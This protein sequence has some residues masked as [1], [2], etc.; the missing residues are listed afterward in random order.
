MDISWIDFSDKDRKRI[1][2]IIALIHE[3]GAVDELGIGVIRDHFAEKF[4]PGTSTIQTK[5]KYFLL[6]TYIFK[7]LEEEKIKDFETYMKRL[8]QKEEKCAKKLLEIANKNGTDKEGIIGRRNI[9]G[10]RKKWVRRRPTEIYWGGLRTY[11]IFTEKEF[12]LSQYAKFMTTDA[13]QKNFWICPPTYKQNWMDKLEKNGGIELNKEE[14]EF[15]KERII[16]KQGNTL[17]GIILKKYCKEFSVLKGDKENTIFDNLFDIV[18][19]KDVPDEIKREYI[20]AKNISDFLYCAQIRYN[21][22]L[23][24][25]KLNP[26]VNL[27]YV[28]DLKNKWQ[29]YCSKNLKKIAEN[30]NIENIK[31]VI[32]D[33]KLNEFLDKLKNAMLENK[34]LEEK[35]KNIDEI[36]IE[37]EKQKKNRERAK[38][39]KESTELIDRWHGIDKLIYRTDR[40]HELILDIMKGLEKDVRY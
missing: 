36:V 6:N 39:N 24:N 14:A 38:L 8:D 34:S 7:D 37:R 22:I 35:E 23:A 19:K 33:R 40:A 21:I 12:S 9:E 2:D 29:I 17:L 13:E 16:A 11:G 31:T 3:Q 20:W 15:L 25:E 10:R 27:S 4:F 32:K 18:M 30:A 5:A 1:L 26:N 28:D